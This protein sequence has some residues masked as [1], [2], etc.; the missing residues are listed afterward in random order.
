MVE[1]KQEI[2]I[3]KSDKPAPHKNPYT[4]DKLFG[5]AILGALAGVLVYYVY[6][7]MGDDTKRVVRDAVVT[8]VKAQMARFAVTE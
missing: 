8:G 5:V 2:E 3:L 1:H 7:Q 6:N 4:A